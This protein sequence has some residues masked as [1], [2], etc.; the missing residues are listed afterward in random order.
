[1]SEYSDLEE[2][3][4]MAHERRLH[5]LERELDRRM[6]RLWRAPERQF[7]RRVLKPALAL[8]SLLLIFLGA[9]L[10]DLS[11]SWEASPIMLLDARYERPQVVLREPGDP[12]RLTQQL[13]G[14]PEQEPTLRFEESGPFT[15]VFRAPAG[16]VAAAGLADGKGNRFFIMDSRIIKI[17]PGGESFVIAENL[18]DP[19]SLAFDSEGNLLVLE[20][21]RG[22]ILRVEPKEGKIKAGSPVSVFAEG[23]ASSSKE[24]KDIAKMREERSEHLALE[25]E[26][27]ERVEPVYLAVNK[28]GEIFVGGQ[29]ADGEAVVYKIGRKP[30]KWWKFYC[31]YRC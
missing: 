9:W 13:A 26:P 11:R 8:A 29:A 15:G 7:G 6:S 22:R 20:S 18:D 4:K 17:A 27:K 28:A 31:L 5:A 19:R 14:V 3:L 1:M 25:L 24:L 10:Y 21:G 30:F 2:L 23:F 16:I 12:V